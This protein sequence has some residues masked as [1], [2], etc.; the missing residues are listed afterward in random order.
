MSPRRTLT[1]RLSDEH[2][3]KF[4]GYLDRLPP[5]D[6]PVFAFSGQQ[7][8]LTQRLGGGT[9]Y[10]VVVLFPDHVIFST[11]RMASTR[12]ISRVSRMIGEIESLTV[13][14]GTLMSRATFRFVGGATLQLA[15]VSRAEAGPLSLFD[16]EGLAAFDRAG[17]APEAV[18]AFFVACS[19][20]LALPDG[21]F[22]DPD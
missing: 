4:F 13:T 18:A 17:L 16:R 22:A 19:Q 5:K 14:P 20:A 9:R 10:V 1:H 3:T 6:R 21:L 11:R 15:N 12:E 8:S 7:P 2:R